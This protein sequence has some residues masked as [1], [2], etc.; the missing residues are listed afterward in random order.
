MRRKLLQDRI[1]ASILEEETHFSD[2]TSSDSP[3]SRESATYLPEAVSMAD[4]HQ[5]R[6][7]LKDYS[8][9]SVP[10]FFTSIA[11]PEVQAYNINYPHS[12]IHLIQGNLFQGLPNEDPYAHLATFIEIREAKRWLHSFKE[13]KA[14]ISSFHQFPDES[15]SEAL[16]RFRGLLRKTPTH[17]FSE[18]TQLNMFIDGLRP[19]TK[20]L[21][22]ASAGGKI[23]LKIPEEATELIENMSAND[24][25]ILCDRVHQPTKKSLLQVVPSMV[26]LMK[27]ANVFSLKKTLKNFT[28]WEI[29]RDKDILKEDSQASNRRTIKPEETL[30]QFMQVTMSNYKNTESTLKNLEVK[31][32]KLAKQ[33][34]DKSSNSFVANTE[35]NPKEECKAV[36]TRSKR[37]VEAKD[38]DNVLSKKKAAEKKGTNEKKDDMASRKRKSIGARPTAQYDTR[39]FHSLDAWNRYTDNVLGRNILPERKVEI[40]HTEFNDFKTELE[41]SEGPSPKQA[42]VRGHLVK[43]DVENLNTFLETPVVIE[44]GET[45][46]TYSS[47]CKLPTDYRE[48]EAALCIPGRVFI[49]N[50]EGH[51][52]RILKKDLTTLALVWSVLSYSNLAPTSHTSDLTVDRAK[53]IFIAQSNSFRL[54]FP[55]LITALCRAQGVVSDSLTFESLSPVIDL[56][57]IRK[58][59]WNLDD[60]T[61]AFWG[62]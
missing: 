56:A 13:G 47:Y 40:Y 19:Q 25:A 18:P 37:F 5:Q 24:H 33:I 17:G 1:V 7:T 11:R 39:R 27:Q 42:R 6:V 59:C 61:V 28:I 21:L 46:P 26:R 35:K 22:D 30:T 15:L 55:G 2:S 12:L 3:S 48:I 50:A 32:G 10:Q 4:E 44:E 14:A 45:L 29:N 54:G 62:G 52:G 23:K 9:S 51:P 34:A 31:V 8:S 49:L 41:A 53:L 58:N 60:L 57:Y 36:M 20:Q 38:E 16:E 43:I